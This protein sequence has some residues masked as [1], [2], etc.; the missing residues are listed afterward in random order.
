MHHILNIL[1]KLFFR[2]IL[3]FFLLGIFSE[4]RVYTDPPKVRRALKK[5]EKLAIKRDKEAAKEYRNAIKQ[6]M[7]NQAKDTRK[8][9]RKNTGKANR[10]NDNKKEFFLIRWFK[11]KQRTG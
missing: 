1:T 3:C 11:P 2:I 8:R 10:I 5:Q 6:H 9:M 7:K 4:C